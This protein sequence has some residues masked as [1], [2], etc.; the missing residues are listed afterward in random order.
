[1]DKR[2]EDFIKY[3]LDAGLL[4][5]HEKWDKYTYQ[6]SFH[7]KEEETG[8]IRLDKGEVVDISTFLKLKEEDENKILRRYFD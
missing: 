6:L 7:A 8:K 2:L 1:M 3:L 5:P 4:K